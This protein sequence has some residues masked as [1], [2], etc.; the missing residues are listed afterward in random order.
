M[1]SMAV[2]KRSDAVRRV[3]VTDA[4][5]ADAEIAQLSLIIPVCSIVGGG[6]IGASSRM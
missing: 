6:V 1:R 4:K 2:V 3:A 5:I